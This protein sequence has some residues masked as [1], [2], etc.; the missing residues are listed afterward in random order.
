MKLLIPDG[1]LKMDDLFHDDE[2]AFLKSIALLEVD[3]NGNLSAESLKAAF[4]V[5]QS[6]ILDA[7]DSA[8]SATMGAYYG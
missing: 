5:I 7:T 1:A 3:D 6:R 2:D 8:A 4:E